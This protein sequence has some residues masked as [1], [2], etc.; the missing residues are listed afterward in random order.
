MP[1]DIVHIVGAGGHAKVVIA[2]LR[3][4]G[5]TDGRI[6][7][8]TESVDEAG[9]SISGIGIGLLEQAELSGAAFHVAIGNN[10]VR[11][12]LHAAIVERGGRPVAIS[13]PGARITTEAHIAPGTF[14]AAGAIIGPEAT[15]GPGVIVNHAAIVDHDCRIGGF[16]HIAPAATLGGN[17]CVGDGVLIGASATILPGVS[18]C[19]NAVIGA[20]AVLTRDADCP[21]TYMGVPAVK[22][23]ERG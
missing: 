7:V 21:A 9:G 19:E 23:R 6:R 10:G 8:W 18:I 22:R 14:I 2:A 15:V 13:H 4:T 11:R 20:G 17:V 12:R 16:C 1:T 5:P 3:E